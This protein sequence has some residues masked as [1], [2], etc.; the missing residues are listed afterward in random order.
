MNTKNRTRTLVSL[1]LAALLASSTAFAQSADRPT[2]SYSQK[3]SSSLKGDAK[4]A[5]RRATNLFEVGNYDAAR[6]EFEQAHTLSADARV[7]YNVAVCDKELERYARAI[8]VLERSLDQGGSELPRRYVR[9]VEQTIRALRPFVT[10]MTVRT[11]HEGASVLI[12]DEPAGRTPLDG[13]LSVDVGEHIVRLEKSGFRGE[14]VRVKAR[15]GQPVS[16]DLTLEPVVRQQRIRVTASGVAGERAEVLVDGVVVGEVPWTGFVET[17]QRR[18][19][20]RAQG[21]APRTRSVDV[22]T[23]SVPTINVSLAETDRRGRVRVTTG[24]EQNTIYINGRVVGRGRYDGRLRAGEH[25]LR[26]MRPGAEGY[27]SDFVLRPRETRTMNVTLEESGGVPTWVWI[28]GGA[29][30][31]GATTATILWTNRETQYEGQ[32]PGTLPPR[33]VPASYTFR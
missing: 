26:V 28:A 29:V 11:S 27:S 10:T 2:P 8:D 31:A 21:F 6:V 3:L 17:G 13:P 9:R 33:V 25:T 30:V 7:L 22:K 15:S 18:I 4:E 32:A 14:P 16:V 12:D 5:F 1:V 20:V 24:N 23:G 19:T